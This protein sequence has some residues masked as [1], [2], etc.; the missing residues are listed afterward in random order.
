MGGVGDRR[1]GATPLH[2]QI[3]E[4]NSDLPEVGDQ[5]IEMLITNKRLV[6]IVERYGAKPLGTLMRFTGD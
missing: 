3:L 1:S 6:P 2:E 5:P 4:A